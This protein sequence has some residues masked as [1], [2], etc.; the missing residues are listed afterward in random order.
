MKLD[1][2]RVSAL[3]E[4]YEAWW[5]D[6]AGHL[7]GVYP[8]YD[9]ALPNQF[10]LDIGTII[11]FRKERSEPLSL[12]PVGL[13]EK[14][15][16]PYLLG[17]RTLLQGVRRAPWMSL[18][19]NSGDWI[20][21]TLPPHSK[22]TPDPEDFVHKLRLALLDEAQAYIAGG[23][24]VGILLSGGMDSRVVAGVVRALQ[25]QSDQAF[26][27]VGL[28]WG[29]ES[30]RDVVYA[31][32]IANRFGW[33]WKHYS[34]SADTLR[35]NIT[36]MGK[37]GAEVSP[38]HLHAMEGVARTDG[39]D[40]VL[41][42]SYGDSVGRAEFSGRRVT[43]LKELLSSPLDR[44]GIV[45]NEALRSIDSALHADLSDTLHLNDETPI[46]RQREIEQQMHYMRRMLQACMLCI[47]ERKRFYQLFTS[48]SVFGLMWGLNPSVRDDK[49]YRRLLAVL[50]GNLLDIPW[51]RTGRR[52]DYPDG[53]VD[54]YDSKYH[55]YGHWLRRELRDDVLKRINSSRI[56]EIGIFNDRGIDLVLSAWGRAGT[57][58]TNSL[59]ELVSWLASLHDF[60]EQYQL[61]KPDLAISSG[62]ID[63]LGAIRGGLHARLYVEARERLRD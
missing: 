61:D 28:T 41:A 36:H 46:L 8:F 57:K 11:N 53:E 37:M 29:C 59:D 40:V 16:F 43:Q 48:P 25:E 27:V 49:W 39:I 24:T 63:W 30:S 1:V 5:A 56:R 60:V 35:A 10:S 52:Y 44:F 38:L 32:Q 58:T 45:R 51:A 14:A 7:G 2:S 17:N 42:G 6:V 62:V 26:S 12:D 9:K 31:H 50:P 3:P 34:I 18:P 21:T 54:R 4:S 20:A 19:T 13:V 22:L 47:A 23:R 33:D 15:L 55:A